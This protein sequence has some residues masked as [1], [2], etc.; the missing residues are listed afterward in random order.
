MVFVGICLQLKIRIFACFK[1]VVGVILTNIRQF[2]SEQ[3]KQAIFSKDPNL[4][5]DAEKQQTVYAG[6]VQA[7]EAQIEKEKDRLAAG[8]F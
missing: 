8:K 3:V 1:L 6:R 7:L 5:A 4:K 2:W